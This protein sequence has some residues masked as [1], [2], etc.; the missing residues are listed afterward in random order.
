MNLPVLLIFQLLIVP[1]IDNTASSTD[2]TYPSW[3]ENFQTCG[4]APDRMLWFRN[5]YL[6]NEADRTKWDNSPI[7]S[8][9]ETFQKVPDAWIGVCERDILRDEGIR[10][11]DKLKKCGKKA[12][13]VVY[14]NAPHQILA[15]DGKQTLILYSCHLIGFIRCS[16]LSRVSKAAVEIGPPTSKFGDNALMCF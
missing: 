12:E 16:C 15:M 14:Q 13:V 5:L 2:S 3:S 9:D 4:L 1:V 7:F 6:P 10:Y 11:G 8:P